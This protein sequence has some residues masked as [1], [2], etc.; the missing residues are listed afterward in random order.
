[1]EQYK[2]NV[3]LENIVFG[4]CVFGKEN[5]PPSTTLVMIQLLHYVK[6]VCVGGRWPVA[7]G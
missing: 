7:P 4:I 3:S 2:K 1:M 6:Y 5:F